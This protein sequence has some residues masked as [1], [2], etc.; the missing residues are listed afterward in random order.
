MLIL[1]ANRPGFDRGIELLATIS[2]VP[3]PLKLLAEDFGFPDEK[4]MRRELEKLENRQEI[5]F[6]FPTC[7]QGPAVRFGTHAAKCR[8]ISESYWLKIYGK[9]GR[10]MTYHRTTSEAAE[11]ILREGFQDTEGQFGTS[12]VHR[13][14]WLSD[15]PLNINDGVEGDALLEVTLM[16]SQDEMDAT[17]WAEQHV[18]HRE[19][20][21]PAVTINARGKG[22][23]M[24]EA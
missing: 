14:V 21:M 22:R 5:T 12:S 1:N 8:R 2:K 16:L 17:E 3:A 24:T 13:G 15:I 19:W 7:A 6:D 10:L 20:L 9:R 18:G 23:L 4:S 11:L